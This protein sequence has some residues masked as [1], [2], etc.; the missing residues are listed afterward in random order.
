MTIWVVWIYPSFITPWNPASAAAATNPD[1]AT[2]T[3]SK[4]VSADCLENPPLPTVM[5]V[6]NTELWHVETHAFG[7]NRE[8]P[9][10]NT[11]GMK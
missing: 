11:S 6:G 4:A 2:D 8:A 5:T 9:D 7:G 3:V 1:A 10:L